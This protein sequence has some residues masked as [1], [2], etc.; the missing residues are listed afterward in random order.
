[1]G[2]L[3]GPS[4]EFKVAEFSGPRGSGVGCYRESCE[5]AMGRGA[6]PVMDNNWQALVNIRTPVPLCKAFFSYYTSQECGS[7]QVPISH[8]PGLIFFISNEELC[9]RLSQLK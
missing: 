2:H 8:S 3:S 5:V 1:M 6:V 9:L 4:A 7:G